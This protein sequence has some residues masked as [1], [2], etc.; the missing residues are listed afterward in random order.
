MFLVVEVVPDWKPT[1]TVRDPKPLK[2]TKRRTSKSDRAAAELFK[3]I[4][5]AEPCIGEQIQ[6]HVCEF[7]MQACHVVSKQTLRK[8]GLG[9]LVYDPV[10]GVSGCYGIHRRH[11]NWIEKI[12]RHLL[13]ARCFAW[14]AAHNLTAELE[15]AWPA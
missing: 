3:Q 15:R 10:N 11:D 1:K 5:D 14:A 12:P 13:P 9:H 8:R 7:P 2:S 4:V 6:G